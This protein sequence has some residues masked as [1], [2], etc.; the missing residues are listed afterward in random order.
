MLHAT[1]NPVVSVC[2]HESSSRDEDSR[3]LL[4]QG[5]TRG[6]VG[7]VKFAEVVTVS[8]HEANLKTVD[9]FDE[10]DGIDVCFCVTSPL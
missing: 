3:R 6:L 8:W 2:D 4:R 10:L 5:R 7:D 9:D 1:Q